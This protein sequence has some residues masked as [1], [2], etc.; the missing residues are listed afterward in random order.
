MATISVAAVSCS[1]DTAALR[2]QSVPDRRP[3]RR[4]NEV[5]GSV[6]AKASVDPERAVAAADRVGA[7]D[8]PVVIGTAG[9]SK[10]M[11]S[12]EPAP[13]QSRRASKARLELGGRHRHHGAE[14]RY[15]R[16]LVT[17]YGVP[18]VG[19]RPGQQHSERHGAEARPAPG[20][21]EIRSDRFTCRARLPTRRT[22]RRRR[23]RRPRPA[24]ASTS[25]SSLPAR[26]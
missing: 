13:A 17:R 12:Y 1:S 24:A 22:R 19:D 15:H 23:S 2:I 21:P 25:M 26:R 11:A 4:P 3:R 16:R 7:A 20:H 5:T 6:A 18:A 10:G 14:G 9:G 8:R